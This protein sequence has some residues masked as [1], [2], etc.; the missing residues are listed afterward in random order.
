MCWRPNT[1]VRRAGGWSLR[2]SISFGWNRVGLAFGVDTA[3]HSIRLAAKGLQGS[4]LRC[5]TRERLLEALAQDDD[6]GGL[7]SALSAQVD[8]WIGDIAA[9]VAR[10]MEG[11]PATELRLVPGSMT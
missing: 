10:D 7:K 2:T 4:R 11:R 5:M 1:R 3:G 8:A 9:A 6:A